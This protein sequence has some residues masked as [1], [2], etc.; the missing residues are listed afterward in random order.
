[1]I[2]TNRNLKS[3]I[4]RR[5]VSL[6]F[7]SSSTWSNV[8]SVRKYISTGEKQNKKKTK[9]MMIKFFVPLELSDPQAD[10]RS[11]VCFQAFDSDN[12]V[13]ERRFDSLRFRSRFSL[14]NCWTIFAYLKTSRKTRIAQFFIWIHIRQVL[15]VLKDTLFLGTTF[16]QW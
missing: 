10:Q 2:E 5:S 16:F 8:Y 9:L 3:D 7:C 14:A 4:K 6:F 15:L 13:D 12:R 11:F 1:M